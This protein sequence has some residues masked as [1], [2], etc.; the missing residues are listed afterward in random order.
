MTQEHSLLLKLGNPYHIISKNINQWQPQIMHNAFQSQEKVYVFK[1]IY[2]HKLDIKSWSPQRTTKHIMQVQEIIV[3]N[4]LVELHFRK[5][6]DHCR[7]C[8]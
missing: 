5:N 1:E 6:V 4:R 2:D 8:V 3:L 7:S